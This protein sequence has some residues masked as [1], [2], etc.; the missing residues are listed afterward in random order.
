ML[1]AGSAEEFEKMRNPSQ[2][3]Q[4]NLPRSISAAAQRLYSQ[5]F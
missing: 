3:S 4:K 1:E 2:E 5:R